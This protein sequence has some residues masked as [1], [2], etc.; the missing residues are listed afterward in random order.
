V[1]G[2]RA[3]RL[4]VVLGPGC[5]LV[6]VDADRRQQLVALRGEGEDLLEVARPRADRDDPVDARRP[7]A[8]EDAVEI[9]A[10]LLRAEVGVAVGQHPLT[11]PRRRPECPRAA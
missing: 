2:E 6:R 3:D 10:E 5:R 1:A 4:G 8:V 7:G 9:G 11:G